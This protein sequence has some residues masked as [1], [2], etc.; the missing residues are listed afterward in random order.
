MIE[1]SVP[2]VTGPDHPRGSAI[3]F[4]L[5]A[6]SIGTDRRRDR[7]ALQRERPAGDRDP[8]HDGDMPVN[9]SSAQEVA[10][11][12][13]QTR[14]P[15]YPIAAK[16]ANWVGSNDP[17]GD[18]LLTSKVFPHIISSQRET[19]ALF[20]DC[21]VA[22]A[23]QKPLMKAARSNARERQFLCVSSPLEYLDLVKDST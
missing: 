9:G 7:A 16:L 22:A 13:A 20:I 8:L 23:T 10:L 1:L 12:Q 21:Y 15:L 6:R 11:E 2:D 4:C 5:P 18:V 19:I 3:W 17:T 14:L